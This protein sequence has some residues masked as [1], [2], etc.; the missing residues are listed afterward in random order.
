V[1]YDDHELPGVNV[2]A[3]RRQMGVVLQNGR[4]MPGTLF[5]NIIGVSDLTMDDAWEAA[6]LAGL[7]AD[8]EAMPMGMFTILGEGSATIS[9]GQRQ[10]LMIARAIAKRPRILLFD[11]AT[12]ALDNRTQAIVS[13]SLEKLRAT[14]IVIAHR[15]STIIN[16]DRIYVLQ[17]GKIVQ[18]GTYQELMEREGLFRDLA[19]RQI[20]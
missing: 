12:S 10:R 15:L 19:S 4:L 20:A 1:Y 18:S 8:I 7:S 9:G 2:Q 3:V 13:A 17:A 6:R 16:A 14:R 5:Q 11:E